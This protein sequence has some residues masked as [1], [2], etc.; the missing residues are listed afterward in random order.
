MSRAGNRFRTPVPAGDRPRTR[1][2]FLR[3]SYFIWILGPVAAW[4]V[5]QAWGLPHVIF[6][7]S[8]HGGESGYASRWYTRCTFIGPYGAFT[9]PATNGRCGWVHFAK[10]T[11]EDTR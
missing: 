3:A 4:A 10:E 1:I 7:Y 11:G 5:Y 6:S 2:R 9:V 8:Y